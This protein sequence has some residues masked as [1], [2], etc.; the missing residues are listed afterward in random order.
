[1][2]NNMIND[3]SEIRH[4]YL[5]LVEYYDKLVRLTKHFPAQEHQG[6]SGLANDLV[7]TCML[8]QSHLISVS[9]IKDEYH[10]ARF[11]KLPLMHSQ[12]LNKILHKSRLYFPREVYD[13]LLCDI[14]A[15]QAN[16]SQFILE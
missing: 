7:N 12:R 9:N 6:V 16:L 8:V 5:E 11:L 3:E 10:R 15:I 2:E 14:L 4:V 13:E 1:M